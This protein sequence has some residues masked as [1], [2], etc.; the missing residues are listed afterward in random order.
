MVSN[1]NLRFIEEVIQYNGLD[2]VISSYHLDINNKKQGIYK[3]IYN[4]ITIL[5]CNYIDDMIHGEYKMYRL[6][7]TLKFIFIYEHNKKIQETRCYDNGN[8]KKIINLRFNEDY[9]A[10]VPYGI[11]T[12]YYISGKIK[13]IRNRNDIGSFTGISKWYYDNQ[14]NT[15]ECEFNEETRES[16]EYFESGVLKKTFM[17]NI[18][19][20]YKIITHYNNNGN[21]KRTIK[22]YNVVDIGEDIFYYDNGNIKKDIFYYRDN[23]ESRIQKDYFSN[24]KIHK[25][26]EY[27]SC[28]QLHGVFEVYHKNGNLLVSKTYENGI[29]V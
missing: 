2:N 16:N 14:E 13:R 21:I 24:G 17:K 23:P 15:V 26:M 9:N 10:S 29:E 5:E 19:N 25:K 20:Y 11:V 18:E 1:N 27:N 28:G 4:D 7:G 12:S 6:D 8:I 3:N 22:Y